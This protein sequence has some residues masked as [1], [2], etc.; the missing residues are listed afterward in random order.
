MCVDRDST[1]GVM[2]RSTFMGGCHSVLQPKGMILIRERISISDGIPIRERVS[3]IELM[4]IRS[5]TDIRPKW[6][7]FIELISI[8]DGYTLGNVYTLGE[9]Y[10]LRKDTH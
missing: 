1:G 3:F 9:E 8:W 5:L 4:C 6:I 10:L 2:S 7:S